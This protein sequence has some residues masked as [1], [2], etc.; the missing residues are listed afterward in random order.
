MEKL[1]FPIIRTH[2]PCVPIP[3][4]EEEETEVCSSVS[5]VCSNQHYGEWLHSNCST[6]LYLFRSGMRKRTTKRRM[7]SSLWLRTLWCSTGVWQP[8]RECA[9]KTCLWNGMRKNTGNHLN[10]Y[11]TVISLLISPL[12]LILQ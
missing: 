6:E 12:V 9:L 10:H 1:I 7:V 5:S 3:R 4:E 11:Y 8:S 2:F